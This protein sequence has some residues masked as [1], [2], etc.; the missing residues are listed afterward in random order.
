MSNRTPL[1]F[2]LTWPMLATSQMLGFLFGFFAAWPLF[3]Y[4]AGVVAFLGGWVGVVVYLLRLPS[5]VHALG[6]GLSAT[7][8]VVFITPFKGFLVRLYGGT[9]QGGAAGAQLIAESGQGL[10]IWIAICTVAGLGMLAVGR[11]CKR[12]SRRVER[13]RLRAGVR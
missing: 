2:R 12:L 3:E 1:S 6:S 7:A 11:Y 9:Q 13:E 8:V 5:P 4:T 10:L